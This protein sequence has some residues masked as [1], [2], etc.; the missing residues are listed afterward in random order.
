MC[1]ITPFNCIQN[2][3]T[4][5]KVQELAYKNMPNTL[6][7]IRKSKIKIKIPK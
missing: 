2:I 7:S 4:L 5:I 3:F 6:S 1:K